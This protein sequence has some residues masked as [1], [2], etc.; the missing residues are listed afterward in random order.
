ML[1]TISPSSDNYVETMNT[2]KY[3]ERLRKASVHMY[4]NREMAAAKIT[5]VRSALVQPCLPKGSDSLSGM[6][7]S[8]TCSCPLVVYHCLTFAVRN[9]GN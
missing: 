9:R 8:L 4:W 1:A 3:A 7:C 6:W 5:K 2:L